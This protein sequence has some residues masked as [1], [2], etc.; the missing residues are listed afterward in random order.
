MTTELLVIC[1]KWTTAALRYTIGAA[2]RPLSLSLPRLSSS[3]SPPFLAQ[4]GILPW[5]IYEVDQSIVSSST[6]Q[7]S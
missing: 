7:S 4:P 5:G 1:S 2:E 6:D 3:S